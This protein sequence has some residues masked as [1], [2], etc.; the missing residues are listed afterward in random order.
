MPPDPPR[1][2]EYVAGAHSRNATGGDSGDQGLLDWG[3]FHL[4]AVFEGSASMEC[5]PFE[6][7][8]LR[9]YRCSS[10]SWRGPSCFELNCFHV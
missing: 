7:L 1:I 8:E 3:M 5:F 6:G 4:R 9:V 10:D 2:Y